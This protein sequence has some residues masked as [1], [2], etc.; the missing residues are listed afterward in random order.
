MLK[1]IR[2]N[3]GVALPSVL[4]VFIVLFILATALLQ[5]SFADSQQAG[6]QKNR[7]QAHYLARSGVYHGIEMLESKLSDGF[8]G[9]VVELA[10]ELQAGVA[11]QYEITD[12]GTY[13]IAFGAV[14]YSGEIKIT[15]VG[16]TDS[17]LVSTQTVTY[18]KQLGTAYSFTNP[19]G[20]WMTGVNLEKAISPSNSSESY[21]GYAV[22][23]ESKNSKHPIQSPKGS[24][25]PSTFQASIIVLSDY[26]GESL[27]QITNSINL[28][29]DGELVFFTGSIELNKS[30]T[31]LYLTTSDD[32]LKQKTYAKKTGYTKCPAILAYGP[33]TP[34]DPL[35]A[36]NIYAVGFENVD[37]YK[38]FAN[39][40]NVS[41][42]PSGSFA[43][44]KNY[45]V[46][47][48]GG[49]IVD[50]DG[51]SILTVTDKGYYYFPEGINL[52]I[53]GTLIKINDNDPIVPVLDSLLG[54]SMGDKP[55]QWDNE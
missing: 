38:D 44:G 45:G 51:A 40:T 21:L 50:S 54:M 11:G 23:L 9:T 43:A 12:V 53:P 39:T 49:G 42:Y 19:S 34:P 4:L 47:K 37:R 20:E 27:R 15:A 6:W 8:S 35:P 29:F 25:N 3:K 52:R 17:Q 32:V 2:N 26:Q 10:A 31:P 30:S 55:P 18:T 48:L 7:V 14:I 24:S 36:S 16:T 46:V 5:T 41:Y 22:M 33:L 13:T 28:T 1:P